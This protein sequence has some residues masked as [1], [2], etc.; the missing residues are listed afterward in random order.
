MISKYFTFDDSLKRFEIFY[1]GKKTKYLGLKIKIVLSL[2]LKGKISFPKLF[3]IFV[4]FYSY[5][6]KLKTSAKTPVVVN[7]ELSNKCNEHCVFCRDEKG[8]IFDMNESGK[9]IE[10]GRLD[11]DIFHNIV[12]EIK[13]TT[14][15][16]IPY[17]NGEP[18]I[19]KHLDK[20]LNLLNVNKL[21]SMLSSNGILLN[22]K[23]ID[24]IIKEDLDQIKVHVS[25]WTNKVH[26]IQHRLGDVEKIKE[27]LTNLSK[28][29]KQHKSRMIVLVDYILYDHNKHE[30]EE[31]RKFTNDLDFGFNIRPG[32]PRGMEGSEKLQPSDKAAI[33]NPCEWLWKVMTVNWNGDLLPC[34]EYVTWGN[35]HKFAKYIK[36]DDNKNQKTNENHTNMNENWLGKETPLKTTQSVIDTWNGKRIV[37]MRMVHKTKGRAPIP[38]CA[39]CTK[40]GVEYKF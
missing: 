33:N 37:E 20:V 25:G 11:Y 17:V 13:K 24:L 23:N 29:I 22:E 1:S 39:G 2:L 26:Q 34:C 32:N 5:L 4:S 40:T 27:N 31:F 10:K 9:Y 15:L 28:K 16:I 3:N 12:E 8:K 14:L 7:F 38:I 19:Y 18:F 21:G 36:D 35:Y 6:F 30:V